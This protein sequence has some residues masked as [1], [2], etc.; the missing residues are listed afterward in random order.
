MAKRTPRSRRAF[1]RF[2]NRLRRR[3]LWVFLAFGI[4][5]ASTWYFRTDIFAW[6]LLPA[7]GRLSPF[8]GGPPVFTA[9]T[10]LLGSTIG[11]A[12]KGGLVV[13][14]PVAIYSVYSLIRPIL[15]PRQRRFFTV[16]IPASVLF[17]I[18]GAAFAYYVLMPVSV[19]F[20]LNFGAGIAV[21]L[22]TLRE[23]M[24]LLTA[25]MFW[26]GIVFQLPGAMF[27][28]SRLHIVGYRRFK[29]LRK[30]VPA[31]AA[32]FSAIITPGFDVPTQVLVALPIIVLYEFGL[33]LAWAA[34]PTQGN[35]LWVKTVWRSVT[36]L[37][38]RPKVFYRNSVGRAPF[39]P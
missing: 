37:L 20:L 1:R 31:F 21:P 35:Y 11:L 22:I 9:P 8:P 16:F 26:M 10:D 6:L 2:G 17:F 23:Y 39:F 38:R 14:M 24:D 32:I 5:A 30:F 33:F 34:R 3:V 15:P 18:G 25:M 27:L 7:E 29:N 36:W 19:Q 13:A 4:G 28:L 12:L